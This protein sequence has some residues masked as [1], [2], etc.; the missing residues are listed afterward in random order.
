[1]STPQAQGG[2]SY[3][4][5]ADRGSIRGNLDLNVAPAGGFSCKF[6]L[7]GRKLSALF[8]EIGSR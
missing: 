7:F 4:L 8:D 3:N 2:M 1:M 5:N 6:P